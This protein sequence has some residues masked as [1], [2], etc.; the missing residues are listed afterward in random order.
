MTIGKVRI[1]LRSAAVLFSSFCN[2]GSV[3]LDPNSRIET[4]LGCIFL[5]VPQTK[6][7]RVRQSGIAAKIHSRVNGRKIVQQRHKPLVLLR[8]R[9]EEIDAA[10]LNQLSS[11]ARE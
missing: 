10:S 8:F 5:Y 3:L 2:R 4:D 7:F 6:R 11:R 9:R 1:A